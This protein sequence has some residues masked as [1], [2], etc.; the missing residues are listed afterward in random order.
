[1]VLINFVNEHAF[2]APSVS[3]RVQMAD[4]TL[5]PSQHE[6]RNCRDNADDASYQECE[7]VTRKFGRLGDLAPV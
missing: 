1:M 4:L 5:R 7:P 3:V 6:R 2:T